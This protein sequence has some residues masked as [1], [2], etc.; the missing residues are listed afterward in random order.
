M[1][2]SLII[3]VYKNQHSLPDLID[4]INFI[5][6]K[7]DNALLEVVFVVDGSPDQ[8]AEILQSL[9]PSQSFI[10]QLIILSRN[11]GSF[12]AIRVGL[13]YA[14]GSY[15]AVMA[16]DLQEPPEL[17]VDFFKTLLKDKIDIV[18]GV[19]A[20]RDDPWL[21]RFS[22]KLF[23]SSYRKFVVPEMPGG[24]VDIFGCNLAFRDCL[25]SCKEA[26][27]SLVA[28]LF[29][30]GFKRAEI[31]YTRR[32]R[33]HGVSA[34]TFKKKIN[35]LMD[36]VFA[37]TDLPVKFLL[38]LGAVG[39]G[40]SLVFGFVVLLARFFDVQTI[41]GYSATILMILFFGGINMLGL[42]IIG[43]YTWRGYENTK[44]RPLAII[45]RQLTFNKE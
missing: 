44:R 43:S 5:S 41:P 18:I 34:W 17:I 39:V 6:Q 23:W 42:G 13:Q 35:Y 36:S 1:K 45:L 33:V 10:S 3:P 20:A 4:T 19:R 31:V 24:G 40:T 21:S 27:T 9:L 8:S 2:Y 26:N 16:A 29:W 30:L 15:F 28:L 22:A 25:L 37:F 14:T 32:E 7:L 11:F 12:A 38:G